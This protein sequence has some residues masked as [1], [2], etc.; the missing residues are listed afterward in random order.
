M[1]DLEKI[2]EGG[3]IIID[4]RTTEEYAEG[5]IKNSL[6]IPLDKI[7]KEMAWLI[8]DSPLIICCASGARSARAKEILEANG[9]EKVYNGGSWENLGK[10]KTGGACPVK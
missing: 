2:I 7:E 8:K 10:M 1:E 3:A 9:F 6:S 5:H 4:V